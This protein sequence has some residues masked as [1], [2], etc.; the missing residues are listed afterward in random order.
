MSI[1]IGIEQSPLI[2]LRSTVF[3]NGIKNIAEWEW[4][5]TP[6]PFDQLALYVNWKRRLR[7]T[8]ENSWKNRPVN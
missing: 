1:H 4:L 5:Q 3:P 7:Y 6:L 8:I 2:K